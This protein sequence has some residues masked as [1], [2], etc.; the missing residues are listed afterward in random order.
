MA[1][2]SVHVFGIRH[3][4]PGCARALVSALDALA[5][6][7][8]LV[9]GPADAQPVL[10]EL[11]AEGLTPPVAILVYPVD[12]PQKAAFYPFARFSPEWNA[13]QWA[14]AHGV[15]T[16]FMDLPRAAEVADEADG[17]QDA[18]AERL[19]PIAALAEAAGYADHELWW[20]H[21]VEQRRDAVAL[22][23][24]INEAMGAL[25]EAVP[26]SDSRTLRR[27]AHM[28]QAVRAAL[29]DG[30][31]RLAIVCGAW[32]APALQDLSGAKADAEALKGLSRTKT[33]AVWIPWTH[34]RLAFRSGYGAGVRA[35]GW[36]AHLWDAP[37][38]AAERWLAEAAR[39]LREEDL[40]APVPSVVEAMRLAEAL[41][42]LSGAPAVGLAELTAA[43]EAVVCAGRP[44]RLALVRERLELGEAMGHVP[45]GAG[46][47]PLQR[48]LEAQQRRLRL[49]PT[50]DAKPM[51]LDLREPTDRERSALLHR[52]RLL[53]LPWGEPRLGRRAGSTFHE[54]WTLT[55]RPEF[56]VELIAQSPWGLTVEAAADARVRHEAATAP[57][58]RLTALLDATLLADLPATAA[59]VLTRLDAA[60]AL[61]ADVGL[62]LDALPP[63]ARVGRYGDARGTDAAM[64]LPIVRGL[65]TRAQV[66]LLPASGSLDDQAAAAMAER[67]DHGQQ[68]L[69]LLDLA[70]LRDSWQA[71]LRT[72]AERDTVHG[73]LRGAAMRLL[74]SRG[75]IAD[76]DLQR[77]A[78]LALSPAVPAAQAAAWIEGLVAGSGLVLLHQAGIWR[79]LD[80][81]L[82]G[83]S[84][85]T[86]DAQLPLL[87]RAFSTFDHAERRAMGETVKAL[88]GTAERRV[89]AARAL[90]TE[91][92]ELVV[93]LLK[94]ILGGAR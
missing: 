27:E 41:A 30:H 51:A 44:E 56:A 8:V 38:R 92:A 36:Y 29:K 73:R 5:P 91:R 87:R 45:A 37:D 86:F 9:E 16:R 61:S 11:G 67:L 34:S 18:P 70:D 90:A 71:T 76:D 25:R 94:Q 84:A 93:P 26:E 75:A 81:W 12:D 57:L 24:A 43:I 59:V 31:T 72:L 32:H 42:A 6:D 52:L 65:V 28:R 89:P 78:G 39:L 49:K 40:D 23:E 66:G 63:L 68:A 19:D 79:A 46:A 7:V 22:F 4:G 10:A 80:R 35:P 55:W 69:D 74:V 15:P 88:A 3:H 17:A 1:G 20:E 50:P 2:P 33:A 62:M 48:D 58:P 77:L 13:L 14:Q 64:V 60:A 82:V 85:D 53:Q 47:A 83:L 54:D 21:Q